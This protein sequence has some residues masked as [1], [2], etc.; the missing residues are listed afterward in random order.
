MEASF[1]R[2][3]DQ[4]AR[5]RWQS[6]GSQM[7]CLKFWYHMSGEDI[8]WLRVYHVTDAGYETLLW[9]MNK[10]QG[11]DWKRVQMS[12]MDSN[13]NLPFQVRRT[14]KGHLSPVCRVSLPSSAEFPF[15]FM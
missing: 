15:I 14:H 8:G 9:S 13:N 1:P 3:P 4:T 7:A 10:D 12:L 6:A 2:E 5:L 11:E